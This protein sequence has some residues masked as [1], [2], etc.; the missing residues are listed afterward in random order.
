MAGMN[1]KKHSFVRLVAMVLVS[2]LA[3][4]VFVGCNGETE[5]ESSSAQSSES[6]ASADASAESSAAVTE[7]ST[8]AESSEGTEES[9]Y[10]SE[11]SEGSDASAEESVEESTPEDESSEESEESIEPEIIGS[12]TEDDPYLLFPDENQRLETYSIPAGETQHYAI[13]RVGGTVLTAESDD[14]EITYGGVTYTAKKGKVSFEIAYALAS[15]A[16]PFAI[17]NT[18]K[19]DAVFTISFESPLGTMSNPEK[20]T[21]VSKKNEVSIP[22]GN[23]TGYHFL[24]VAE[25]DG[26]LRLYMESSVAAL[27]SVTNNSNSANRT[28]DE[29]DNDYVEIE[30]KKGD[31][32]VIVVGAQRDKR[33]KI[34]A[35]DISWNAVYA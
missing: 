9:T 8:E 16:I 17:K 20:V 19:S 15:E 34:P 21:N 7:S 26:T 32:L 4:T 3:I 31:E 11:S 6:A 25:K 28:S 35:V 29:T 10:T 1:E 2:L 33:N 30:V 13:Y 12:G 5:N 22:A 27:M 18:D 24:Y 23:E 14:I